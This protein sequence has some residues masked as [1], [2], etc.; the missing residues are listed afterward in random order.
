M[1]LL[2]LLIPL[3]HLVNTGDV[4]WVRELASRRAYGHAVEKLRS[5]SWHKT[6]DEFFCGIEWSMPQA[7]ILSFRTRKS[8]QLELSTAPV[9]TSMGHFRPTY[10]TFKPLAFKRTTCLAVAD[11][12]GAR[13]LVAYDAQQRASAAAC[14]AAAS[15]LARGRPG[16]GGRSSPCNRRREGDQSLEIIGGKEVKPL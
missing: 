15:A 14:H 12:G 7:F 16:K 4:N 1:L 11:E 5:E 13:L 9:R 10:T 2:Q 6:T 8:F 3:R